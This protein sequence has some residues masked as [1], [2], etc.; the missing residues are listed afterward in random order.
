MSEFTDIRNSIEALFT[1]A[2]REAI[3]FVHVLETDAE[4]VGSAD[5]QA[6][7]ISAGA[8]F[9]ETPGTLEVKALAALTAFGTTLLGETVTVVKEAASQ[10]VAENKAP[11]A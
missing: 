2:A 9:S 6:A 7:F 5:L 10:T 8:A 11:T 4:A 3:N 1:P